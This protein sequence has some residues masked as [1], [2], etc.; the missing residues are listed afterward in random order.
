MYLCFL[1]LS[2]ARVDRMKEAKSEAE[3]IISA[4]RAEMEAT[5]QKSLAAVSE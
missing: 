1:H 2:P 5:Y 4:Y 3:Q